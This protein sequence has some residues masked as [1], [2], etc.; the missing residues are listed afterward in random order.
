MAAL[1]ACVLGW[2]LFLRIVW[3]TLPDTGYGVMMDVAEMKSVGP[4]V[5][6]GRMQQR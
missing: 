2:G 1:V 3:P 4:T 6:V 5:G